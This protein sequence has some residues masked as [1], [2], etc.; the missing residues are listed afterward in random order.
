MKITTLVENEL[1]LDHRDLEPEFGLSLLI[2]HRD[3][4]ILFDTGAAGAAMRNASRLGVDLRQVDAVVLSHHHFDHGGGLPAFFAINSHAKVYLRHPPAGKAFFRALWVVSRYI[5]L[6][7]GLLERFKDR[8]VFVDTFTEFLPGAYIVTNI[9]RRHALPKGDRH[10]YV[11]QKDGYVRDPFSHELVLVVRDDDGLIAFTGC[12][13][14]GVLNMVE[15]VIESFPESRIKAVVGGFHLIGIPAPETMAGSKDEMVALAQHMRQ[16]TVDA[17]WTG[18]C[19][20][21]KAFEILKEGLG[22]KLGAF[23]TG[24]ALTI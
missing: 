2:E 5:G 14:S 16:M 1:A 22:A 12:G 17:Y 10:L 23:H 6:E 18:H 3:K 13:H 21:H 4:R 20:G 9:G 11:K 24:T 7:E 15:T 8:F 19:T